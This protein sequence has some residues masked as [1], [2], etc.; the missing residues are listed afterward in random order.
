VAATGG[1]VSRSS[2]HDDY[3]GRSSLR[4]GNVAGT[5]QEFQASGN[6]AV[7]GTSAIGISK[8]AASDSL[9]VTG[10]EV[11]GATDTSEQAA[12]NRGTIAHSATTGSTSNSHSS[13]RGRRGIIKVRASLWTRCAYCVHERAVHPGC[14]QSPMQAR[15]SYVGVCDLLDGIVGFL[16]LRSTDILTMKFLKCSVYVHL[17]FCGYVH[18]M[19]GQGCIQRQG[20]A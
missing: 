8:R 5:P 16:S 6:M 13:F 11:F 12:A 1:T 19:L 7:R 20:R 14:L 2:P 17:L 10:A 15:T 9:A 18:N 3:S 4:T